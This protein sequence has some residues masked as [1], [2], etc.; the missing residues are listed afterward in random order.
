MIQ[1]DSVFPNISERSFVPRD[2]DGGIWGDIEPFFEDLAARDI[3]TMET[4]RR[5]L[6]DRS[7]LEAVISEAV[8]K[9]YISMTIDTSDTEAEKAYLEMVENVLPRFDTQVQILDRHYLSSP[10]RS[11]LDEKR[12]AVLNREV[13]NRESLFR[14]ENIPLET[15]DR[16]LGQRYD[17]LT[18]SWSITYEGTEY[19]LQQAARFLDRP[20]RDVRKAV[21]ELT[22]ECRLEDRKTLDDLFNEMVKTRTAIARNAEF[23][24]YRDFMFRKRS[25]FDYEP[26]DCMAYH[27][28]V[29]QIIVPLLGE[30][31]ERRKNLLG[32][33][34]LR[35]WDK[36]AD[37][38]GRPALHPFD[39]IDTYV[40][41]IRN[42]FQHIDSEWGEQLDLIHRSGL[43]DLESRKGKAPGGYQYP[44][45]ESRLPFIFLHGTGRDANLRVL[46]HEGGHAFHSLALREEPLIW[47]RDPPL[48][49][50]E[51]ASM[52]M[53]LLGLDHLSEF[54]NEE[55]AARSIRGEL[56]GIL[57]T[58]VWVAHVDA[59]QHWI[60]THPN[61]TVEE[62]TKQWLVLTD[63]F[64]D[65][66]DYSGYDDVR[67]TLWHRQGHIFTVP[68]Y[69]IEYGIAQLGALQVWLNYKKNK[70]SSIAALKRAFGL[71]GSRPLPELF[72]A[73]DIRFDFSKETVEP[74]G[75]LVREELRKLPD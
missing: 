51:V 40:T 39:D 36:S 2:A 75:R 58:L 47:Y 25:R 6:H 63:R 27:E 12:Y 48:E 67:E 66:Y 29:E 42:I 9:R 46:L 26:A 61:H 60:Y 23:S 22:A 64:E 37:P 21:W 3:S 24:D 72:E 49:F 15:E 16:K 28:A 71:G 14:E 35:P 18:G 50:C 32:V 56:E 43:M 11:E 5:W 59:F 38:K 1:F 19:T 54:Y 57:E 62:R 8:A 73:A 65:G 17:K 10:A 20:D 31:T 70:K 34:R 7:E 44:L 45:E 30:I 69:Y 13:E 53:E 55:D 33:E 4:L 52:S 41:G 68:F 74:L